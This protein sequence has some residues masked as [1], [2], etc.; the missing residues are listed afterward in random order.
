MW[1]CAGLD[2]SKAVEIGADE[3]KKA[4]VFKD[5]KPKWLEFVDFVKWV[6]YG[7]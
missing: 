4:G 5:L 6:D 2:P 7:S 1:F 3:L